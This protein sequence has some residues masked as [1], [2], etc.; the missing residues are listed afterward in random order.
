VEGHI[1][2]NGWA[3]ATPHASAAPPPRLKRDSV[4]WLIAAALVLLIGLTWL[5]VAAAIQAHRAEAEARVGAE[6]ANQALLL[7]AQLH[8]QLLAIDQSLRILV[9]EWQRDPGRFDLAAWQREAVLLTETSLQIFLADAQG[10]VRASTRGGLLGNDVHERD[11]FSTA[12]ATDD[13]RM[14]VGALRMGPVTHRWQMNLVR[15]LN[16]PDGSFAGIASASLDMT[17]LEDFYRGFDLGPD[18]LIAVLGTTDGRLRALVGPALPEVQDVSIANSPLFGAIG[19]GQDGRWIGPSPPD[20]TEHIVAFRRVPGQ[21]LVVVVGTTRAAA[22]RQ[23]AHWDHGAWI[24][25]GGI[26]LLLLV[27]AA[28]LLRLDRV[29]RRRE[30]MLDQERSSLAGK[31]AQLEATVAGMSDG[32][33]MVDAELRLLA[34]NDRFPD[35][36]GVPRDIVRAGMT[37]EEILRAQAMAGEFGS[38]EVD[39]E[40]AR[41]MALLRSG[42]STGTLQRTRPGGRSMELRRNPI[43]GGGFVTLYSDI[44]ARQQA[45]ERLR[46]AEKMAAVGRLTAGIAHDFNN[47]L[48]SIIG[49]ADLLERDIGRNPVQARR[50]GTIV[51]SAERGAELVQRLLAFA[52][53]QPLEPVAVNLNGAVRGML[54]LLQA[55]IGR[56]VRVETALDPQLWA[57][58][59]DPVQLEH[60]IL[61][62]AINARD[63]M[64]EGGVLTITTANLPGSMPNRDEALPAGDYVS[65][66]VTDTGTGMTEEVLRNAFEPFFTTK[67][68]GHGSGLGLSQVYGMA[69]QSGGDVRID[70]A[71]GRGTTVTV[72]LP[73]AEPEALGAATATG[74]RQGPSHR[75]ARSPEPQ[76]S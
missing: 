62:L 47:L 36:T 70:S 1:V 55:T 75:P 18:G 44:T 67:P 17:V 35:C 65:I 4:P 76:E 54:D 43:A 8:T 39:A 15:R 68:A 30:I 19:A 45:E 49:N 7:E 21:N 10:I 69:S 59:V 72:F 48:S 22:T 60:V 12:A 24:F 73:R 61:N 20:G 25:G 33:M 52:R 71:L 2:R 14:V 5:G 40:V 6:Q 64:P 31:T 51:G 58:L 66:A 46:Q 9:A 32:V 57:A 26:S 3:R 23:V 38:V 56:T 27:L 74:A 34:W 37:M 29:M 16:N 41:R 63:A 53:K 50:L 11:Y 28:A 13:G 42:G